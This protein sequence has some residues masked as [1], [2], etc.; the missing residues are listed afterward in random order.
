MEEHFGMVEQ[1]E[2]SA[3]VDISNEEMSALNLQ[4]IINR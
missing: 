1:S 4:G 3:H 2:I